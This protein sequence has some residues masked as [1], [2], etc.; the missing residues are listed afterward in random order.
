VRPAL[1]GDG[2]LDLNEQCDNGALN[3]DTVPDACRTTCRLPSCGDGVIDTGEECDDGNTSN[4]DHCSQACKVQRNVLLLIAD[5][6]G[7][8]NLQVYQDLI[9]EL[10]TAGPMCPGSPPNCVSVPPANTSA[11]IDRLVAHGVTFKNA[12]SNPTCT[13]TR[14][15]IYSGFHAFEHGLT[16]PNCVE[17]VDTVNGCPDKTPATG[18]LDYS[19][20]TTLADHL[21][22]APALPGVLPA[23]YQKGLFGKWHLSGKCQPMIVPPD[24]PYD[25]ALELGWTKYDGSFQDIS[26]TGPN[27]DYCYWPYHVIDGSVVTAHETTYATDS[28]MNAA[29]T[30]VDAQGGSPWFTTVAFNVPHT[31]LHTPD[32]YVSGTPRTACPEDMCSENRD[33]FLAMVEDM[34]AAIG[35]LINHLGMIGELRYTIIIFIGDNGTDMAVY[36]PS[37]SSFYPYGPLTHAKGSVYEGGVEVP[38]IIADGCLM[39]NGLS[40]VP[41]ITA[42]GQ[43]SNGLVHTIDLFATIREITGGTDDAAAYSRPTESMVPYLTNPAA[44]GVRSTLYTGGNKGCAI[45]DGQYK[46]V[47]DDLDD[48]TI[49]D[50]IPTNSFACKFY[51]L[52]ADPTETTNL[53]PGPLTSAQHTALANLKAA[54]RTLLGW[55]SG[56][57]CPELMPLP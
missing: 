14:A 45:R 11:G 4:A 31:P 34:D 12:W 24:S 37:M 9:P 7:Q 38:M 32:T 51:D 48:T 54:L 29:E 44:T 18:C 27:D 2:I 52:T 1:C 55:G 50:C 19:L 10:A 3:S 5:D 56:P 47:M 46:L 17:I 49:N 36:N 21:A 57:A 40:C 43:T 23:A 28:M 33:C 8:E 25:S 16:Y 42:P 41:L 20:E 15:G 26:D 35:R 30:W 53:L 13:P 6:L 39:T 22:N